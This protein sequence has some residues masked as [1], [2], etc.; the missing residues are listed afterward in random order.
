MRAGY[1]G[2]HSALTVRQWQLWDMCKEMF[3]PLQLVVDLYGRLDHR[4]WWREFTA[5]NLHQ[6]GPPRLVHNK[7]RGRKL[8]TGR[9]G[10]SHEL[11][12]QLSVLDFI[13]NCLKQAVPLYPQVWMVFKSVTHYFVTVAL[14]YQGSRRVYMADVE[15]T[16]WLWSLTNDLII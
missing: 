11:E 6:S 2:S 4:T 5:V 15:I 8:V 1:N 10:H 12:I 14:D 16:C 7:A 13:T 3:R 9:T